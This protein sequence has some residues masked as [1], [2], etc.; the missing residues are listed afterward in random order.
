MN[1]S[2]KKLRKDA[3]TI[4]RYAILAADPY[5]A[6]RSEVFLR[7]E[8]LITG[9]AHYD[10]RKFDRIHI[11][12]MGK[13]SARMAQAMEAILGDRITDGL[14][15][16]KDG[17]LA[18]LKKVEIREAGHP[19]PDAR[20]QKS[21]RKIIEILKKTGKRDLVIVLICGGG[22]ALLPAPQEGVTLQDKQKLTDILLRCGATI[23]EINALRK[24]LSALKGGRLARLASPSTV[25][26]LILS[27]IVG[28]PVDAIASG[29]TA[30][31][32]TTFRDCMDIL[33]RYEIVKQTPKAIFAFIKRGMKGAIAETPKKGD[34]AFL[35]THNVIVGNNLKSL[36]AAS[37]KATQLGYNTLI[38]SSMI[39]G[40]TRDAAQFHA[41]VG[42]EILRSCNPVSSPAC[43]ISGGETTVTIRGSGLG[44]RNQEFA[45]ASAIE[46]DALKNT[47][48]LSAGSDGTDGPTDAA[49]AFSDS[50][51][52][53][54]A[55]KKKMNP[56]AYLEN[57]DS[58]HFF[59]KLDDLIV[60]G[61]TNTNVMDI[62]IM[63]VE[64]EA[65]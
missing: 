50:S 44:G 2:I 3:L 32:A 20:G 58:Y 1:R 4:L 22:S 42:K 31:D 13:G 51:T 7:G 48:V 6:V 19:I 18:P 25:L 47:V 12:G 46:I 11:I 21:A 28:D 27:D 57:N 33:K 34:Q 49:G 8:T 16:V 53:K 26:S 65:S 63:L 59:K 54:R 56:F 30:P 52:V 14:A 9:Q 40:E 37:Q 36:K 45:L 62:R 17:Y 24:H 15:V 29:P 43:I 41:F 60:T 10:M 64:G 39:E 61:P 35:R 23:R 38:L 55:K 5:E